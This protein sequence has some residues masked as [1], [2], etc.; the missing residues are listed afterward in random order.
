MDIVSLVGAAGVGKSTVLRALKDRYTV[1]EEEYIATNQFH[2][3]ASLLLS[4]WDWIARWYSS[5]L[6]SSRSG[7]ALVI[8]D[9]CPI[10]CLAFVRQRAAAISFILASLRELEEL[11]ITVFTVCMAARSKVL[12]ARLKARHGHV[13]PDE[14]NDKWVQHFYQNNKANWSLNIDTTFTKPET[15][16]GRVEVFIEQVRKGRARKTPLVEKNWTLH[17]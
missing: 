13:N 1:I 9:R 17:D 10:C 3:D 15:V 16:V 5:V 8:T 14:D 12:S 11:K 4:K 7:C 2:L 6:T